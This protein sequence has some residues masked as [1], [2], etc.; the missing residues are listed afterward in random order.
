MA[1]YSFNLISSSGGSRPAAVVR[2][3]ASDDDACEIATELLL[4]SHFSIIEV[5]RGRQVIYRVSK[6]DP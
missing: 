5:L 1:I 3:A 4:E 2:E 6:V